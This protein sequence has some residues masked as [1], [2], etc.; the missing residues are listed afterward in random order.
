M[1][2]PSSCARLQNWGFVD[3]AFLDERFLRLASLLE[4]LE[5]CVV[6]YSGGV[7]STFLLWV[8]RRVLGGRAIG[9]LAISESLDRSELEGARRTA[10]LMGVALEV[11]ETHEYQNPDYLRNDGARCY[12]CKTELFRVIKD[13]ARSRGIL[14]VLDG[15]NAEDMDDFRPG[16]RARNEQGVRSPLLE[17]GLLKVAIRRFS[18]AAG[19]PTWDK[20]AAPC[21]SSR[22]PHGTP[23]TAEK[24]RQIEAAEAALRE[25]GFRV[26]RVRHHEQVA[27]VEVPMED[28]ARLLESDVRLKVLQAIH[29]AGFLFVALDLDGFRSGSLNAALSPEQRAR[30]GHLVSITELGKLS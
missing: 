8:A 7:D 9:V 2:D 1:L 4:E 23:V 16:L 10:S 25:L 22:I 28:F 17:A 29:Q 15:S 18:Q 12:H 20:P 11:L 3:P 21:L 13:F 14:H 5:S 30:A 24:L 19:L 26:V 6:A 27:R